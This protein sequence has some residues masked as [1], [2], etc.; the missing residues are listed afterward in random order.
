MFI[1]A[2]DDSIDVMRRN[3][4]EK[5]GWLRRHVHPSIAYL[6]ILTVAAT[7][8]TETVK[9]ID[10]AS[11]QAIFT[12]ERDLAA[13]QSDLLYNRY[14]PI[15]IK[16]QRVAQ[17]MTGN[18]GLEVFCGLPEGS[19]SPGEGTVT[20]GMHKNNPTDAASFI[21]LHH[22]FCS[23]IDTVS[24]PGFDPDGPYPNNI[25]TNSAIDGVFVLAHEIGHEVVGSSE[26]EANCYAATQFTQ[27][28]EKLGMPHEISSATKDIR[29]YCE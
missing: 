18:Y 22:I 15:E 24:Q 26:Q 5:G 10:D 27:I 28:A 11:D 25:Q 6:S 12:T 9:T 16:M 8:S 21:V 14:R 23:L 3:K 1:I 17:D 20:L 29:Q 4:N 2:R 19:R 13:L 7:G